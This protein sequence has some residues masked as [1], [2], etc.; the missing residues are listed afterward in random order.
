MFD[1]HEN[2]Q[3]KKIKICLTSFNQHTH[4]QNKHIKTEVLVSWKAKKKDENANLTN[5][6]KNLQ[7]KF[8]TFADR[9]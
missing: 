7:N 5:E 6:M 2:K 9:C 1:P 4:T 3:K 8:L